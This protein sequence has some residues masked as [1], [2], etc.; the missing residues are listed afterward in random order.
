MHIIFL[1]PTFRSLNLRG[2]EVVFNRASPPPAPQLGPTEYDQLRRR[3]HEHKAAWL[4]GKG[5][6][7]RRKQTGV[8]ELNE[9]H[10]SGQLSD[11]R[12][13]KMS[14]GA[15]WTETERL[16]GIWEDKR[17]V[18]MLDNMHKTSHVLQ[19][20]SE[21]LKEPAPADMDVEHRQHQPNKEHTRVP[22]SLKFSREHTLIHR[23]QT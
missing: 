6:A 7:P 16:G 11:Q 8:N 19:T 5:A 21:N 18:D 13:E 14:R 15:I 4:C 23:G 22:E 20:F 2:Q 9:L 12:V 3:K 10:S 17:E 1:L